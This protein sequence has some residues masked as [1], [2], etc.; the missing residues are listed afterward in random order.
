MKELLDIFAFCYKR[1]NKQAAASTIRSCGAVPKNVHSALRRTA[2]LGGEAS[3]HKGFT[4]VELLVVIAIIGVLIALLLPAVQ[5]ARE[6]ARRMQCSNKLKQ[7][8]LAVHVFADANG[9]KIPAKITAFPNSYH[10]ELQ[11]AQGGWSGGDNGGT[12]FL[13]LMP[14]L[15]QVALFEMLT[16]NN[17][18]D[19]LHQV[20]LLSPFLCPSFTSQQQ[21][22]GEDGLTPTNYLMCCGSGFTGDE[23]TAGYFGTGI[24]SGYANNENITK[25]DLIVPDGTS[26]TVLFSEGRTS[27]KTCGCGGHRYNQNGNCAFVTSYPNPRF[28]ANNPPMSTLVADKSN[29]SYCHDSS[30]SANSNHGGGVN[31]AKG[32]GSGAFVPFT[33]SLNVWQAIATI[34]N[35]ES[36]NLP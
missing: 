10:S 4:L 16:T 19:S 32:D 9:Q 5:A 13:P 31:I 3:V 25:G 18:S 15:E 2:R 30:L 14:F 34:Q 7:L 17:G 1:K 6:A 8:S 35:G 33:V 23:K 20:G 29:L 21:R 28:I 12:A 24:S 11:T 26:N 36:L 22:G 27:K